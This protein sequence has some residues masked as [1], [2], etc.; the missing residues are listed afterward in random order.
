MDKATIVITYTP[1]GGGFKLDFDIENA[2]L[3]GSGKSEYISRKMRKEIHK[4][5]YHQ[6]PIENKE[7]NVRRASTTK[8]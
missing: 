2:H 3:I 7:Q 6:K 1:V 5:R 8:S 4:Q